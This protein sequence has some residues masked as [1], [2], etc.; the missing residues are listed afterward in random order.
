MSP[1]KISE[2]L[3]FRNKKSEKQSSYHSLI[4]SYTS[5][6]ALTLQEEC[7]SMVLLELEKQCSPK[8]WLTTLE[9]V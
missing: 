2:D 9:L 8:Q 1:T 5:R 4:L 3:I 7:Y 6:L